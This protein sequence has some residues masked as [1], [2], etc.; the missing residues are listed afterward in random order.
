MPV[1][2]NINRTKNWQ[3]IIDRFRAKLCLW[4]AKTL[5]FGGRLTLIKSVLGN[6]PNYYL[7]LFKAPTGVMEKLETIR[8]RFLWGGGEDKRKIH[9]VAW[10]K[11]VAPK[12]KGGLG[13]GSIQA[14]NIGLLVK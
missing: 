1:G 14:I 8:R 5:S 3:P 7:S 10:D 11:V 12:K 13:V 4:K 9:W 6:L 2:A